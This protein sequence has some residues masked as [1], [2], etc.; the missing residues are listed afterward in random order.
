MYYSICNGCGLN[1]DEKWMNGDWLYTTRYGTF[2]NGG[3]T[4]KRSP[5]D[6]LK[7]WTI[8]QSK[9]F[10]RKHIGKISRSVKAYVCLIL[11]CQ[12]QLRSNIVGNSASAVD[13]Q[14]VFK[15]MFK[16]LLNKDYSINTDIDRYQSV[17]GHALSKVDFSVGTRI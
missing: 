16:A 1:A 15:S 9:G 12:V 14:Q 3:K 6:I 17:L 11:N 4:T 10:T 5:S 7:R 13:A 8:T 2:S